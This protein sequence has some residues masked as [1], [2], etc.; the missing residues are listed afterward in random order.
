VQIPLD[1]YPATDGELPAD[2]VADMKTVLANARAYI[3]HSGHPK[4]DE[5]ALLEGVTAMTKA[6][7]AAE[8]N[9]KK[10]AAAGAAA[11]GDEEEAPEEPT[12]TKAGKSPKRGGPRTP[13]QEE[14]DKWADA[15]ADLE[16]KLQQAKKDAKKQEKEVR[17]ARSTVRF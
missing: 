13:A 9:A 6:L 14:E 17:I 7:T 3:Q 16:A 5:K 1:R 15:R 11:D 4:K 2:F 10:A 8:K 12:P